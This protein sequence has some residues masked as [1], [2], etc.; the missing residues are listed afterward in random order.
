MAEE[1]EKE[2]NVNM[3]ELLDKAKH[4]FTEKARLFVE[5]DIPNVT[6]TIEVG[7]N[8]SGAHCTCG[9]EPIS[10][11]PTDGVL[12]TKLEDC[13]EETF[14]GNNSGEENTEPKSLQENAA[15][16]ENKKE[17]MV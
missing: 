5:Y 9:T 8:P 13:K 6:E 1:A 4:D 7:I 14:S 17:D 11:S 12:V 2:E 16:Q 15:N 10:Y 3:K